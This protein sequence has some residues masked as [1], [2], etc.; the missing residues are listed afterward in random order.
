M[1]KRKH[2]RRKDV[3]K[4]LRAVDKVTSNLTAVFVGATNGI[5]LRAVRTFAK[6]TSGASPTIYIVGR[7][8]K[9]LEFLASSLTEI[10]PSASFIPIQANDLTLIKDAQ[11]AANQ[12][13][14]S[15]KQIDPLVISPGYI[16]LNFDESPEG[17]DRVQAIRYYPRM[18][19]LVALAPL[20]RVSLSPRIV[21][22]LGAGKEGQLWPEYLA[23]ETT[24][25][26]P[27]RRSLENQKIGLVHLLPGLVWGTGLSIKGLPR[28]GQFL[29]DWIAGP[30]MRSFGYTIDEA[31]EKVLYAATSEKF[32]SVGGGNQ[33]KAG[34]GSDG[35]V[36]SGVYLVQGNSSVMPGNKVLNGFHEQAMDEKVWKH[37][38]EEFEK[39]DSS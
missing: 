19:F 26:S 9:S 32:L 12:I 27:K 25:K 10:N 2:I 29:L 5:G 39:V 30:L 36:G 33:V 24:L 28:W 11:T 1:E 4:K 35:M 14:G 31:G 23:F 38:F 21:T 34:K 17:L 13:A 16:S 3:F 20:L 37:T 8:R 18:R 15:A 7:S 22:I 6:H